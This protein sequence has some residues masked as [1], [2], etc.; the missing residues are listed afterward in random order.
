[1]KLI[2]TT[3]PYGFRSREWAE[4]VSTDLSYNARYCYKVTFPDGS[5]DLWV[6]DDPSAR[7]EFAEVIKPDDVAAWM[8]S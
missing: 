1:M 2:R 4:L 5:T 6:V 7:Y 8:S 3:H